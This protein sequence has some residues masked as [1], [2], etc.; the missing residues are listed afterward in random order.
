MKNKLKSVFAM[1]AL[2]ATLPVAAETI[3][4]CEDAA[5]NPVYSDISCG[6]TVSVEKITIRQNGT[7][8]SSAREQLLR[9]EN[10]LLRQRNAMLEQQL[11]MPATG[12]TYAD[13]QSDKSSSFAC[14]QAMRAYDNAASVPIRKDNPAPLEAKRLAVYNACGM[15]EPHG[16]NINIR[17]TNNHNENIR[18][19]R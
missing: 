5:G 18:L 6:N 9:Q 16:N 2:A 19:S 8:S 3:Y 7:E 13:L 10:D 14:A 4:R 15:Q 11:R 17:T 1:T 12:R